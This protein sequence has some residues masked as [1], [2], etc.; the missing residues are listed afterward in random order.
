M[1][2]NGKS[3]KRTTRNNRLVHMS[4]IRAITSLLLSS[5]CVLA[6]IG[7]SGADSVAVGEIVFVKLIPIDPVRPVEGSDEDAE[8]FIVTKSCGDGEV[9]YRTDSRDLP[10]KFSI[11]EWCQTPFDEK[12]HL[13]LVLFDDEELLE[14][15]PI[16]KDVDGR[17]FVSPSL[18]SPLAVKW[19]YL[20]KPVRLELVG[21]ED[22]ASL[23]DQA[24]YWAE[25]EDHLERWKDIIEV[26]GE[27]LVQIKGVF[28]D[29]V[30]A[31]YDP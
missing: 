30:I 2:S 10:L 16:E 19:S 25:L 20:E 18:E 1:A 4:K 5:L 24:A 7:Q 26:R 17:G 8:E 12:H 15:L 29:D 6:S 11:G 27:Y 28:V 23:D 21:S 14:Y 9:L 31:A 3:P 13:Q 22:D